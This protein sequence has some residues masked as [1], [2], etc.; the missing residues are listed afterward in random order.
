MGGFPKCEF[1]DSLW[2]G[3]FGHA[4]SGDI[5]GRLFGRGG[6]G[7][8][9]AVEVHASEPT[10]F[11]AACGSGQN[12]PPRGRQDRRNGAP[13]LARLGTSLQRRGTRRPPRQLRHPLRR[14]RYSNSLPTLPVP[15]LWVSSTAFDPNHWT[16]TTVTTEPGRTPQIEELD[17]RS[18]SLATANAP[19]TVIAL[20]STLRDWPRPIYD[21]APAAEESRA[22]LR[23]SPMPH[24]FQLRP[25]L[26]LFSNHVPKALQAL[27]S[28][29]IPSP[30]PPGSNDQ[31]SHPDRD[32]GQLLKAD[33]AAIALSESGQ[34][35]QLVLLEA[36][37][38]GGG[39][40]VILRVC[41]P[42]LMGRRERLVFWRPNPAI[43]ANP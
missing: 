7:S 33:L 34:E 5:A 6:S 3:G 40:I 18:S 17:L 2:V 25:L 32:H 1:S 13:D 28:R 26:R 38:G 20:R 37:F 9:L 36:E 14:S 24:G 29:F 27:S 4:I 16:L 42:A 39:K 22:I 21:R 41:R 8:G 15:S 43:L 10:A 31:F 12:R 35:H 19:K 30:R 11:V 23:P